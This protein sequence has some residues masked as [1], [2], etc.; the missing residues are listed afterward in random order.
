MHTLSNIIETELKQ[1]YLEDGDVL[2]ALKKTDDGYLDFGE[3]YFSSVKYLA[4]KAWKR[5]TKMTMNL[6]VPH[7]KINF[8]MTDGQLFKSF[9]LS[10]ENYKRLTVPPM[11]WFGFQGLSDRE[12]LVL[13]VADVVHHPDE[14]E[15]KELSEIKFNWS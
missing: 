11:I 6:I 4:V 9:V 12:S 10:R 1:V 13:N 8:V 7:G 5:H 14:V 15:R 2:H 3:A